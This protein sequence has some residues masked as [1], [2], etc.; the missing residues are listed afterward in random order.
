SV[1]ALLKIVSDTKDKNLR[2]AALVSLQSYD[3][4]A[5]GSAVAAAYRNFPEE[6]RASALTLLASRSVWA[7]PLLE[8]VEAG[9]IDKNSIPQDIER[10]LRRYDSPRQAELYAK[11]WGK[12]KM[13]T[14][15]DMQKQI[16][17]LADV[18]RNGSGSP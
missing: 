5:I 17:Q 3:D 8:S 16:Q 2:K 7:L 10:K 15:A 1:P 9:R 18:I 4:P 14:T 12:T 6:I 13:P 11:L